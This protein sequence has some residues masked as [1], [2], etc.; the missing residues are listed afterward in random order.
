MRRLVAHLAAVIGGAIGFYAGLIASI[1]F[2]GLEGGAHIAPLFMAVGSGLAIGIA[3]GVSTPWGV[4]PA[5]GVGIVL[6]SAI[7][8]VGW[9]LDPDLTILV[10]ALFILSQSLAWWSYSRDSAST[11]RM[12]AGTR[13]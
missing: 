5:S 9:W 7:G 8:V 3:V 13:P 11:S 4:A 10:V 2:F 6:G 1:A 12:S